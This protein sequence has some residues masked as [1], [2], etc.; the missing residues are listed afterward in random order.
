MRSRPRS[1]RPL[2]ACFH[3]SPPFCWDSAL[4]GLTLATFHLMHKHVALWVGLLHGALVLPGL[5]LLLLSILMHGKIQSRGTFMFTE[6]GQVQMGV[7]LGMFLLAAVGGA[8]LFLKHA[9]RQSLPPLLI[10]AHGG[11]AIVAYLILL[12][13]MFIAPMPGAG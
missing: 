3:S 10:V 4:G 8:M 13:A 9:R 12:Y 1:V 2:K 11:T 7:S 5:A 6:P